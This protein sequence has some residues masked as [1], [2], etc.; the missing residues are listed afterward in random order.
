M[1]RRKTGR[2]AATGGA[3][4][5][6]LSLLVPSLVR[7]DK[8]RCAPAVTVG[9]VQDGVK[10]KCCGHAALKKASSSSNL[11][12]QLAR[13]H[14]R[15]EPLKPLLSSEGTTATL[16]CSRPPS[17]AFLHFLQPLFPTRASPIGHAPECLRAGGFHSRPR[18]LYHCDRYL[19]KSFT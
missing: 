13:R 4:V 5:R 7:G 19:S 12:T 18:A 16:A 15:L 2:G 17:S 11:R 3:H 8:R 6:C 14:S 1:F 10:H 9:A